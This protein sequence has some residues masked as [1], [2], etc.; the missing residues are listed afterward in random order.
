[1]TDMGVFLAE[2]VNNFIAY[3]DEHMVALDV[4]VE[5]KR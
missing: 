5:I 2:T 1:M 4:T 3:G